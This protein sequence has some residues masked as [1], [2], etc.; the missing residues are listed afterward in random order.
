LVV[1][2]PCAGF[3]HLL[4]VFVLVAVRIVATL[5]KHIF[6]GLGLLASIGPL[7]ARLVLELLLEVPERIVERTASEHYA[8]ALLANTSP[9]SP[10]FEVT[11]TL[12]QLKR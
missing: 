5:D 1:S 3:G 10:C 8:L 6:A 2:S 4:L 11:G 7:Q 9:A 12:E